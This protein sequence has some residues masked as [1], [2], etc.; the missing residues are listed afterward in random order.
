MKLQTEIQLQPQ[1]FNQIDYHSKICLVGSCFA[2]HI[3]QK[4][5]Y[6]KFQNVLNP[7]GILFH[8]MAIE[9]LITAAINKKV[10]TEKDIFFHNEQWH[11]YETHS[12]LSSA[13]KE[14]LLDTLNSSVKLTHQYLKESTH[15][16]ITLGTSWVYRH[17]ETDSIV[18][19]CH[20]I[21]QKKFV[22]EL[23]TVDEVS[24]SFQATV[25]LIRSINP[26]ATVIF[27]VSPVRHLKDG[28]IENTQSKSHLIAAI[29]Q[30][31]DPRQNVNYF[32]SYE[33][34]MDQL[35][36]YRFYAE[37]MIHPNQIAIDF[38]WEQFKKVWIAKK[39]SVIMDQIDD[40]RKGMQHR[41]FHPNSEA[42]QGFLQNLEQKMKDLILQFPHLKF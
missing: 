19:N 2:E 11:C 21:P 12:R 8:P 25:S 3:G 38:I 40:I 36:D 24:E 13:S 29:H 10:Y 18:T 6:F 33:I 34:M 20:K 1:V 22:K 23:L 27:T 26:K 16:V 41:P 4:L 9:N 31:I 7:F 28:F 35:R 5:D 39:A 32:P 14:D 15:I 37:D 30:Y 42:H 17:I